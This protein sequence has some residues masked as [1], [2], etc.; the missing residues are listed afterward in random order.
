MARKK[1]PP[2]INHNSGYT[3]SAVHIPATSDA[4]LHTPALVGITSPYTL[5][6]GW[7]KCDDISQF[8]YLWMS[9]G[10]GGPPVLSIGL[11]G[12]GYLN[13]SDVAFNMV[14]ENGEHLLLDSTN[15]LFTAGAWHHLCGYTDTDH[16]SGAKI[17]QLYYDDVA[18]PL[19]TRQDPSIAFSS[20]SQ[21]APF[22]LPRIPG[23]GSDI[24]LD[25]S[26]FQLWVGVQTDLSIT[27]NRR[28][29][30]SESGKPVDPLTAVGAY[31]QQLVFFSGDSLTFPVNQGTGGVFTLTGS[32]SNASTSP[33]D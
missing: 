29:F 7:W 3:A 14:G 25:I 12:I 31:G 23:S 10:G 20:I 28:N 32:L 30:I 22:G 4:G 33:S 26:D 13:S 8:P 15:G 17:I 19:G 16:P 24:A 21:D 11:L 6:S 5:F 9:G 27:A 2:H 18:V 1:F